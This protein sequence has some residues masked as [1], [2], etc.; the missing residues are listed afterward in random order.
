MWHLW[1]RIEMYQDLR[2]EKEPLGRYKHIG[3]CMLRWMLKK[4]MGRHIPG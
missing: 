3:E 1:E 4:Y 2:G